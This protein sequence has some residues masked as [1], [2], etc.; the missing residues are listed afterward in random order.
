[1]NPGTKVNADVDFEG[2]GRGRKSGRRRGVRG[3]NDVSESIKSV[4]ITLQTAHLAESF[5]HPKFSRTQ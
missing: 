1:M 2:F 5:R 4:K 3:E